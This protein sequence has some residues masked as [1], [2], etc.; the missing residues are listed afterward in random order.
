MKP[1]SPSP[2]ARRTLPVHTV[3]RTGKP[4]PKSNYELFNCNNL[5]IRYWSWN[6]RGCWPCGAFHTSKAR[7]TG[8]CNEHF[9]S[10]LSPLQN[11]CRSGASVRSALCHRAGLARPLSQATK[12]WS[13]RRLTVRYDGAAE[14]ALCALAT[15]STCAT[16]TE[17]AW[18]KA[19]PVP[20]RLAGSLPDLRNSGCSTSRRNRRRKLRRPPYYL[21]RQQSPDLPSN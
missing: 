14:V 11:L 8:Q 3:R 7:P 2:A 17:C 12:V 1:R 4:R 10:A 20:G 9:L 13:D 15:G 5:N 21:W 18:V 19:F 6:Y 16:H